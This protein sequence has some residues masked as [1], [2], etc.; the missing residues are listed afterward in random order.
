MQLIIRDSEASVLF[1]V[2]DSD[3]IDL[4][5]HKASASLNFTMFATR[6]NACYI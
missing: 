4:L 2:L 6:E 1:R 3:V 5:V